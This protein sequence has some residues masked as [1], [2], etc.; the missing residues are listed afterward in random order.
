MCAAAG[1]E[2]RRP[3]VVGDKWSC[4]F[5]ERCD[6]EISPLDLFIYFCLCVYG[7]NSVSNS[8]VFFLRGSCLFYFTMSSWGGAPDTNTGP[9]ST[10]TAKRNI[11]LTLFDVHRPRKGGVRLSPSKAIGTTLSNK[12]KMFMPQLYVSEASA[13]LI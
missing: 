9:A 4:C 11:A 8:S 6:G 2:C 1:H 3:V 5:A 10:A 12:N 13:L 7:G